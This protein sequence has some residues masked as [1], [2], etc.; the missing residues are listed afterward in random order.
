[1]S[2]K[3][4]PKLFPKATW[5]FLLEWSLTSILKT[6]P[7]AKSELRWGYE[8]E[9]TGEDILSHRYT[10]EYTPAPL[11]V[12]GWFMDSAVCVPCVSPSDYQWTFRPSMQVWCPPSMSC[13]CSWPWGVMSYQQWWTGL[14]LSSWTTCLSGNRTTSNFFHSLEYRWQ[15]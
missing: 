1:M 11:K 12:P 14:S 10:K 5:F 15:N 8:A 6:K 3:F 9:K 4:S 2:G 13:I 7:L